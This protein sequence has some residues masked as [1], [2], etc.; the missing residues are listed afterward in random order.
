MIKINRPNF[1][2]QIKMEENFMVEN[3]LSQNKIFTCLS[4]WE[5]IHFLYLKRYDKI[6][7]EFNGLDFNHDTRFSIATH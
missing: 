1:S 5:N 2:K 6:Q 3:V 7:K 4:R